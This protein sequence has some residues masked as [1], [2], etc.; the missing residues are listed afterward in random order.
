M[1]KIKTNNM[2]LNSALIV[3]ILLL[4]GFTYYQNHKIGVLENKPVEVDTLI[5]YVEIHDTIPGKPKLVKVIDL[6]T[7]YMTK[8]EY[9]PHPDYNVLLGQYE[10]LLKNHFTKS[11][12]ETKFAMKPNGH[13]IV[14]DTVSA[15]KIVGNS[16]VLDYVIPEKTIYITEKAPPTRNFY[17]GT[18]LTGIKQQ[19]IN[20]VNVGVLY[21]DKTDKLF[22]ASLGYNGAGFLQYGFSS[23]IKI[24]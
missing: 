12:Y 11:V 21:K 14:F 5:E 20:S 24:K 4:V 9:I 2:K 3:I 10:D 18:T 6:D 22:G 17:L 13:V 1:Q 23:Y 15:N 7:V 8:V 16:V 19:F